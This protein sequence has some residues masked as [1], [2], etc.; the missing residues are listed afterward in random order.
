MRPVNV[1]LFS[2]SLLLFTVAGVSAQDEDTIEVLTEIVN[3]SVAVNDKEGGQV[4]NLSKDDFVLYDNGKLTDIAFFSGREAPISYGIVYDLHPTTAGQSKSIL[5]ALEAFTD[6]L[7]DREDFFLTI[8]NEYGSL[9]INFI[10]TP[11]QVARHLSFG[12]RN[13]P[14]SLYDAVYL[15]GRKLRERANQKKTL[16]LIS[17]GKDHQSHHG[18]KELERLFESFSVQIYGVILDDRDF[19]DYNELSIG[20]EPSRLEIDKSG[21]DAAAIKAISR[22]SGGDASSSER[23]AVNLYGI[24]ERI[25]NDMRGRYSLGFYPS[26]GG[27]HSL[28]IEM[29]VRKRNE[30]SLRYRN[31]YRVPKNE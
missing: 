7:G 10:P 14:N 12:E 15:A 9:N 23:N 25:S 11:D 19:W 16:I 6:G 26:G 31:S 5:R 20:R 29:K 18:F 2:L 24:F 28:Q 17:D 8:F 4:Q 30:Y 27:S 21:L 13:E 22:D 3:V 1:T